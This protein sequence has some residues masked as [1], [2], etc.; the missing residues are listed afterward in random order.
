MEEQKQVLASP[1]ACRGDAGNLA[2]SLNL[3]V[4]TKRLQTLRPQCTSPT[5]PIRLHQQRGRNCLQGGRVRVLRHRRYPITCLQ[6]V[7]GSRVVSPGVPQLN[8]GSTSR[9]TSSLRQDVPQGIPHLEVIVK[10]RVVGR[11]DEH[12]IALVSQNKEQVVNDG[13]AQAGKGVRMRCYME[14]SRN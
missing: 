4:S 5:I 11:W 13:A 7:G 8:S 9:C 2:M 10:G 12:A 6:K 3:I 1:T 14:I